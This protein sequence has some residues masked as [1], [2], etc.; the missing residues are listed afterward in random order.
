MTWKTTFGAE[1]AY[2]WAVAGGTPTAWSELDKRWVSLYQKLFDQ[3]QQMEAEICGLLAEK[4][5]LEQGNAF[6]LRLINE[7]VNG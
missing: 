5:R 2:P 7:R 4:R 1:I 6:M 3:A